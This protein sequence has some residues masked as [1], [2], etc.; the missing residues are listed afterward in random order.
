MVMFGSPL[1]ST[2][3]GTSAVALMIASEGNPSTIARDGRKFYHW[4]SV[5]LAF[6]APQRARTS[7]GISE[8]LTAAVERAV[9]RGFSSFDMFTSCPHTYADLYQDG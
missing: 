4:F 9:E 5:L 7:V 3:Q 2:L 8:A 1:P 6:I